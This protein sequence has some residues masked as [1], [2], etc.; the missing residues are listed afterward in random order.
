[1]R[2]KRHS[3]IGL[4]NFIQNGDDLKALL[5]GIVKYRDR[6]RLDALTCIN[7]R[8]FIIIKIPAVRDMQA[9]VRAAKHPG[10]LQVTARLPKQS[11]RGPTPGI[12][13]CLPDGGPD[14]YR[15]VNQVEQ[16][17]SALELVEH[18]TDL[19]LRILPGGIIIG[20]PCCLGLDCGIKV[21]L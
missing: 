11:Q 20:I 5:F 2:S 21:S 10:T 15:S 9:D 7:L 1:M 14:A 3:F 18:A 19:W 8:C 17:L 12:R 4:T 6:L 13:A 16:M